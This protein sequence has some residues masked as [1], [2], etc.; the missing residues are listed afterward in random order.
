MANSGAFPLFI[1]GGICDMTPYDM[2]R[3]EPEPR[4]GTEDLLQN[5]VE[6]EPKTKT[7]NRTCL[8][9]TKVEKQQHNSRGNG[10]DRMVGRRV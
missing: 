2:A 3:T 7:W 5:R 9:T 1:F 6:P 10:R 4:T 8:L